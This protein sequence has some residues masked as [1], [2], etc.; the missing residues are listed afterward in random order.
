MGSIFVVGY[1]LLAVSWFVM[2]FELQDS[3]QDSS[4]PKTCFT[5]DFGPT[6]D[7]LTLKSFRVS[8]ISREFH[9]ILYRNL[10]RKACRRV[11]KLI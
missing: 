2:Y 11:G 4:T 7:V 8:T 10:D 3:S 5:I 9:S 6:R 1:I